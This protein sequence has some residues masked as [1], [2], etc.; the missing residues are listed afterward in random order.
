MIKPLADLITAIQFL[1]RLPIPAKWASHEKPDFTRQSWTFPL[2][3]TIIALPYIAVLIAL[4]ALGLDPYISATIAVAIY[5]IS[6][7][8]LHEDGLA[9][10]ADGFGGGTTKERKLEIMK[11]SRVGA[12]GVIALVLAL[13][14]HILALGE[15]QIGEISNLIATLFLGSA[16]SQ[17]M[18]IAHW[19]RLPPAREDGL[20]ASFGAPNRRTLVI[21]GSTCIPFYLAC[22]IAG[23]IVESFLAIVVALVVTTLF[24]MICKRQIG[25]HTGDTIG[26]TQVLSQLAFLVVMTT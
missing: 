17:F 12:F 19:H 5:V 9:D 10:V 7:G 24:S 6:T 11:D 16:F 1:S 4:N 25:G 3:G 18:V 26:A 14:L 22:Q 15:L 21:A 20:A 23:S 2:A 8:M 13:Q